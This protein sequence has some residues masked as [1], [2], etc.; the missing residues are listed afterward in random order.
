[1]KQLLTLS[2]LSQTIV[3]RYTYESLNSQPPAVVVTSALGNTDIVF[4]PVGGRE[5][6][7]YPV[8]KRNVPFVFF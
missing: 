1:M 7:N 5:Y 8:L 2:S 3:R 6:H 4:K